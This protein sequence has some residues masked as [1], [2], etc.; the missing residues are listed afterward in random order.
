MLQPLLMQIKSLKSVGLFILVGPICASQA[1]DI[2]NYLSMH[3][4]I[5]QTHKQ[6]YQSKKKKKKLA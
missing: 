1:C 5:M 3:H 4:F 2:Q 6:S